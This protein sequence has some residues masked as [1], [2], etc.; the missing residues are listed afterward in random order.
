[1]TIRPTQRRRRIGRPAASLLAGALAVVA[2][3]PA[4]VAA[5]AA[6]T[7]LVLTEARI[8]AT[9]WVAKNTA[10]G[11][12]IALSL[13]SAKGG[14]KGD[15]ARANAPEG[16][17]ESCFADPIAAGDRIDITVDESKRSVTVP[18]MRIAAI[19]RGADR[20]SLAGTAGLKLVVRVHR[21]ALG[22]A[23]GA[24]TD[25]ADCGLRLTRQRQLGAEGRATLDTTAALDLR[26][27]DLVELVQTGA[28]GDRFTFRRAVPVLAVRLRSAAIAGVGLPGGSASFRL[29]TAARVLRA[30][31]SLPGST[32]GAGGTFRKNGAPILARP[33]NRIAG[34]ASPNNGFTD[35]TITLP[36]GLSSVDAAG[37]TVKGTCLAGRPWRVEV[38]PVAIAG[39]A[40]PNGGFT[41][42][43]PGLDPGDEVTLRCGTAAGD[44]VIDVRL[45]S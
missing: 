3:A 39:S 1:M 35:V 42:E 8:G 37:D 34:S 12:D 19:D 36:A 43:V 6:A 33:G 44:I 28:A 41:A 24:S 14:Y 23:L 25:P 26:G 7:D 16:A 15:V 21:C 2:L 13:W 4:P 30:T 11:A 29:L 17:I 31:A 38:G 20:V 45:A 5:G 32:D 10:P 22:T 40:Q 27:H 18:R 9:C